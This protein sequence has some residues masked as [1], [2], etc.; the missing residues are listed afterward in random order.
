[1]KKILAATNNQRKI[2]NNVSSRKIVLNR[3]KEKIQAID[4]KYLTKQD[5][6]DKIDNCNPLSQGT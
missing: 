5:I 2:K 4:I 3:L 6:Y 1:M